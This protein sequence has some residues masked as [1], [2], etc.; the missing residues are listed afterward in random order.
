MLTNLPGRVLVLLGLKV[1]DGGSTTFS[2]CGDVI[3]EQWLGRRPGHPKHPDCFGSQMTP[4]HLDITRPD[5]RIL[6]RL[7]RLPFARGCA[8]LAREVL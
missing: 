7:R 6:R 1:E 3:S 5:L 4:D 2:W 8:G